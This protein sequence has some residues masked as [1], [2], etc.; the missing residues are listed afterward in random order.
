M[1]I[2]SFKTTTHQKQQKYSIKSSIAFFEKEKRIKA[3]FHSKQVFYSK[4]Y[5]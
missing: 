4:K 2:K 5:S 1:K 3:N